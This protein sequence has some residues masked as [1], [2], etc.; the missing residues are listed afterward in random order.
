MAL[1]ALAIAPLAGL[2]LRVAS[3]G[4]YIAGGDGYLVLDQMQYLNWLRQS[5][6]HLL[7]GNL[8]DLAP[9]PR[10]FLHP[11]LLISG[12]LNALG[13]GAI[14]A[15]VLWKPVAVLALWAGA[16]AWCRRF[17]PEGGR[18]VAAVGLAL[19]F[20]SP[21]AA[22]V[23][24]SGWGGFDARFDFDFLSGELTASNFVWGYYFTGIAV[25]LM[26]LGMLAHERGRTGLAAAA[27][28]IV[29]WLQPWQGATYLLVIVGAELLTR[30]E[31]RVA[32][33]RGRG[34]RR[35]PPRSSTTSCSRGSTTPGGWRARPTTSRSGPG[36]S[37]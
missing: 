8:Y 28:L 7:I 11:G 2:L 30:R 22:L 27:G 21:L 33:R 29:A 9:G 20:A 25:G 18:R 31:R 12:A 15:Y 37:R 16:V 1:G 24:W 5:G 10:T 23:G 4:G 13:V 35:P 26:P 17:L 34:G 19:F 14:V 3:K 36:G 6:S 32:P